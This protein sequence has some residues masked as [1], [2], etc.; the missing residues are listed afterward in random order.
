MAASSNGLNRC[1]KLTDASDYRATNRC[2]TRRRCLRPAALDAF[3]L[4]ADKSLGAALLGQ[5]APIRLLRR[6]PTATFSCP[7]RR[8]YVP[9]AAAPAIGH[10]AVPD[11]CPKVR[12]LH[13]LGQPSCS[14]AL[15]VEGR[16]RA[17]M[18]TTNRLPDPY[19]RAVN[20]HHGF[21]SRAGVLRLGRPTTPDLG[22]HHD[23]I[24][25][26]GRSRDSPPR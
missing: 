1:H 22:G 9:A 25:T 10:R 4:S 21:T 3:A 6:K 2:S 19:A 16:R 20:R 15:D 24:D 12:R 26:R 5:S 11:S 8:H 18:A 14:G 23:V 7:G 13:R 17:R